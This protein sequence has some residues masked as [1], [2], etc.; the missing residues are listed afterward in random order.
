MSAIACAVAGRAVSVQ[1]ESLRDR[2]AAAH[3]APPPLAEAVDVGIV[4]RHRHADF[5][6]LEA[7]A[8]EALLILHG[9]NAYVSPGWY[10]D[11]E[12]AARVPGH[13]ASTTRQLMPDWKTAL[14][15]TSR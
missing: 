6:D 7:G 5:G 12:S 9:P 2:M 13:L 3:R 15:K 1:A 10:P 4:R 14:V 8:G 11:K